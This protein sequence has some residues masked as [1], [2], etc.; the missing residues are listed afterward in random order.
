MYKKRACKFQDYENNRAIHNL[1]DTLKSLIRKFFHFH[2]YTT[3]GTMKH[4]D[5]KTCR[6]L[7]E[8]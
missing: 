2:R 1:V 5:F 3:C 4:Y 6:C 8:C 7:S